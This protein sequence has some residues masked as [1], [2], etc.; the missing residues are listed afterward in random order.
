MVHHIVA[1]AAKKQLAQ[2]PSLVTTH[3]NHVS[4]PSASHAAN[5]WPWFIFTLHKVSVNASHLS[6]SGIGP[7]RF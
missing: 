4:I 6:P 5:T 3:H 7:E 2:P 1:N